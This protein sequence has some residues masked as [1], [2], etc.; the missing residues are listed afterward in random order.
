MEIVNQ[1]ESNWYVFNPEEFDGTTTVETNHVYTTKYFDYIWYY[2]VQHREKYKEFFKK[3]IFQEY[4]I[5]K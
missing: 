5:Q 4:R 3:L 1:I 2:T